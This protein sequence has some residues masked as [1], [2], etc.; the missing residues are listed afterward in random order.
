MLTLQRLHSS[1]GPILVSLVLAT[2]LGAA[3]LPSF[4]PDNPTGTAAPATLM[5]QMDRAIATWNFTGINGTLNRSLPDT[6][7]VDL[8]YPIT[9]G[10]NLEA[11]PPRG[12]RIEANVSFDFVDEPP[13]ATPWACLT[14]TSSRDPREGYLGRGGG[15]LCMTWGSD[16]STEAN[17][18]LQDTGHDRAVPDPV[19]PVAYQVD[20]VNRSGWIQ[21]VSPVH[22]P[23]PD[24]ES[25]ALVPR[26][27]RH[28]TLVVGAPLERP[29]QVDVSYTNTTIR[30]R[31]GPLDDVFTYDRSDFNASL[32][33][34]AD[35][36]SRSI[37]GVYHH[38]NATLQTP[39]VRAKPLTAMFYL[40]GG[41]NGGTFAYP[42]GTP[43]YL[44]YCTGSN[45]RVTDADG[46]WQFILF[47]R[48]GYCP[49]CPV[50]RGAQMDWARFEDQAP[51]FLYR[52]YCVDRNHPPSGVD[53]FP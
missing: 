6:A 29:M 51:Y 28:D 3:A 45:F 11:P 46:P 23:S 15:G 33:V 38:S 36:P 26:E 4:L 22:T 9:N 32:R 35:A 52:K 20:P 17:V 41:V 50:L 31:H 12:T 43:C 14:A 39:M 24:V 5:S 7:W 13:T 21:W 16:G 42:N 19:Q 47:N 49:D 10:T 1:A 37:T 8:A 2:L 30:L 40:P 18:H 53:C 44:E 27:V 25:S 48:T 34:R